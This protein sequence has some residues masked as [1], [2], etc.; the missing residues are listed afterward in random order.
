[1]PFID[2]VE[3]LAGAVRHELGSPVPAARG[4]PRATL[5]ADATERAQQGGALARRGRADDGHR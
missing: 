3:A 1:M 5:D 2:A 4:G